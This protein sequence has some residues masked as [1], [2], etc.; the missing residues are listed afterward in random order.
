[1]SMTHIA[2]L[3]EPEWARPVYTSRHRLPLGW[4][5]TVDMV[6]V[7]SSRATVAENLT[8]IAEELDGPAGTAAQMLLTAQVARLVAELAAAATTT[9]D[10]RPL[11]VTAG[12][13]LGDDEPTP[14]PVLRHWGDPI[15]DEDRN[16]AAQ[17]AA[18]LASWR[19]KGLS[20]TPVPPIGRDPFHEPGNPAC[21]CMQCSIA[22]AVAPKTAADESWPF[23]YSPAQLDG[24]ACARCGQEFA[25]N[26]PNRPVVTDECNEQFVHSDPAQCGPAVAPWNDADD[27]GI[28]AAR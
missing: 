18:T 11:G 26:E 17:K 12:R 23:L 24:T 8:A 19:G 22:A 27:A 20:A 3:P 21:T 2:A 1:M 6:A 4:A 28:E 10:H 13:E 14:A 16:A 9:W 7:A 15:T 5:R 25:V